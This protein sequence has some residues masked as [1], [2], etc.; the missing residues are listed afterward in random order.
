MSQDGINSIFRNGIFSL[1]S[2]LDT[3]NNKLTAVSGTLFLVSGSLVGVK[4]SVEILKNRSDFDSLFATGSIT[5]TPATESKIIFNSLVNAGS[6]K[7][8]IL[9]KEDSTYHINGSNENSRLSIGLSNDNESLYGEGLD[10]QGGGSL[11]FN[12][13][14]WDSELSNSIGGQFSIPTGNPIKFRINDIDKAYFDSNGGLT[15]SIGVKVGTEGLVFNDG[16]KLN[17]ATTAGGVSAAEVTGAISNFPTRSEVTG[18]LTSYATSTSVSSSFA[19]KSDLTASY[20]TKVQVTGAV[21]NFATRSEVSGAITGS[22]IVTLNGNNTFTGINSFNNITTVNNDFQVDYYLS[23]YTLLVDYNTHKVG[24]RTT[25]TPS[26]TL[27]VV[28]DGRYTDNLYL[29]RSLYVGPIINNLDNTPT[30]FGGI[31]TIATITANK[32]YLAPPGND[33]TASFTNLPTNDLK[34]TTIDVYLSQSSAAKQI[35]AVKVNNTS[36]N[37]NWLNNSIPSVSAYK[38]DVYT[39]NILRVSSNWLVTGELKTYG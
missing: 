2:S 29:T 33:F 30:T 32:F 10:L 12:V 23:G 22:G 18:A 5:F 28:G 14:T 37:V 8:F 1:G 25:G 24:I 35:T 3:T 34:V 20:A 26:Y 15:A 27:D 7:A 16:T 4:E 17:T 11:I 38:I 13:G 6:D 36:S 9:Y 31:S 21:A 19:L 39:F